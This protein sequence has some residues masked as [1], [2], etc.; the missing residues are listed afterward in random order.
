M[1]Q[2]KK[3]ASRQLFTPHVTGALDRNKTSDREALQL[4]VQIA[5]AIGHDPSVLPVSRSTFQR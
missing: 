1:K 2:F 4:L 5:A 3:V